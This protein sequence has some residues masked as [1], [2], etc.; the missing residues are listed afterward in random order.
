[1]ASRQGLNLPGEAAA[2]PSVTEQDREHGRTGERTGVDI[3]WRVVRPPGRRHHPV[4]RAHAAPAVSGEDRE[5]AGRHAAG[6]DP[7]GHRRVMVA[8][9]DLGVEMS[10]G[11]AG[12][13][14]RVI[15]RPARWR[16]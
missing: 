12:V 15:A 10:R 5:A 4:A 16:R 8:R 9:G 13:Q 14:K 3:I 6:G 11:G 7:A 1:M 2:L